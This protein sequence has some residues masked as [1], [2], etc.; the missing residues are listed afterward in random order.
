MK[1]ALGSEF[2]RTDEG[3]IKYPL[4]KKLRSSM[5]PPE[6]LEQVMTHPAKMN[7][8][9]CRDIVE[10][11]S[12]PGDTILDCF[13]GVGTSLVGAV[14]GRNVNLIEIE[15]YYAGII[16]T[17][18]AHLRVTNP[19]LAGSRLDDRRSILGHMMMVQAD[20]R[21]AM[22]MPA[23]HI[24]TS[25][26]YGNDLAKES[27]ASALTE[28]IGK[29]GMQYTKANQNIGKL[30][31]FLYEQSMKKVYG[32]MVR[33]VKVGGTITI[34][35]RDRMRNGER[36]LY[37]DSIIGSMVKLGCS[38]Y[39]LDKWKPPGSFAARVNEVLG[40]EIVEDED[41]ITMKRMR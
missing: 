40:N 21:I 41:I 15:D 2:G 32:L 39:N 24:I 20:N 14:L 26:P 4:D 9:L 37:I 27:E 13:G 38:V 30:S 16:N 18:I 31:P 19:V 29:Q 22:P 7:A 11:V 25:P 3:W 34:T 36:I 10:F 12:E 23:D 1:E 17:C 28:E 35:H 8:Y 6:I 5:Y 33:S